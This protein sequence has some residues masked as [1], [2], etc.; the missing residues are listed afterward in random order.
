MWDG[1]FFVPGPTPLCPRLAR[2]PSPRP[3]L[4]DFFQHFYNNTNP[5]PLPLTPFPPKN[6]P[7]LSTTRGLA[8]RRAAAHLPH[9]APHVRRP[10]KRNRS[11]FFF[12]TK[13][14]C[15]INLARSAT[16]IFARVFWRE[17]LKRSVFLLTHAAPNF[18]F[19]ACGDR[20][21]PRGC[22]NNDNFTRRARVAG[23]VPCKNAVKAGVRKKQKNGRGRT[24][25]ADP[26][27]SRIG[28]CRPAPGPPAVGA[29]E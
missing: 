13:P 16:H 8:A 6:Q 25:L 15:F 9:P 29:R 5:N 12:L 22:W 4:Q 21:C 17:Q 23:C 20:G 14:P 10:H 18:F 27:L 2:H 7:L 24:T 19:L 11:V 28:R 26:F 1:D 3:S